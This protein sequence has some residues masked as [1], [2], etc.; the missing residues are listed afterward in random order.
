LKTYKFTIYSRWGEKLFS[1]TNS[2][3]GW[4][5]NYL[6]KPCPAGVYVFYCEYTDFR[7]KVYNTK[8]TLH[9]LR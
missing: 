7:D 3:M 8:G 2:E 6:G 9:L 5:G 1:T 4:D